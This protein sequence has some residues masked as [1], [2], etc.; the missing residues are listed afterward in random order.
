M[1]E[2]TIGLAM[3]SSLEI[4]TKEVSAELWRQNSEQNGLKDEGFQ[5]L[6]EG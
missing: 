4:L 5:F 6:N 2:V 3:W 1:R